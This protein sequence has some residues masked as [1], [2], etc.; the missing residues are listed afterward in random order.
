MSEAQSIND[1]EPRDVF[2]PIAALLGLLLASVGFFYNTNL[3]YST[4]QLLTLLVLLLLLAFTVSA[5]S[6]AFYLLTKRPF[7]WVF[8]LRIFALSWFFFILVGIGI[9]LALVYNY[10]IGSYAE[11]AI[12]LFFVLALILSYYS[13]EVRISRGIRTMEGI[14]EVVMDEKGVQNA[15]KNERIQKLQG[16]FLNEFIAIERLLRKILEEEDSRES[17]ISMTKKLRSKG[18]IDWGTYS[19]LSILISLRNTFVHGDD[20][21]VLPITQGYKLAL[22]VKESLI[23]TLNEIEKNRT[24][25]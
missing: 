3:S 13:L 22:L 2:V 12:I 6:A 16:D 7:F 20:T 21:L 23:Q 15:L 8:F 19:S 18:K 25:K 14:S 5:T 24:T 11:Y 1:F 9:L 4:K 10:N 17:A